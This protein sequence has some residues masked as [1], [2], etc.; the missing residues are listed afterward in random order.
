MPLSLRM[1]DQRLAGGPG[2]VQPLIGEAASER[3]VADQRQYTDNLLFCKVLAL[4]MPS[5]TET[6]LEAW[7]AT[8]ASWQ[9][10]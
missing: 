3:T 10:S 6:E 8:K 5:A 7:P 4:A 9:L 1:N 2:I